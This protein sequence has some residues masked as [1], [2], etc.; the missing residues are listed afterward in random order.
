MSK[1]KVSSWI[2]NKRGKTVAWANKHPKTII[3]MMF[4]LMTLSLVWLLTSRQERGT[5]SFNSIYRELGQAQPY[6]PETAPT[7]DVLELLRLYTTV[8]AIEP[9]SLTAQDSVFLKRIDHQL[10]SIIH[11]K[12]RF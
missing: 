12:D 2:L 11:E 5:D 9:D 4:G 7:A 8:Q 10:N 6:R 3:A 1:R